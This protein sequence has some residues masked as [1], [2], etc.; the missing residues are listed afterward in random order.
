MKTLVSFQARFALLLAAS[1]FVITTATADPMAEIASFSSLKIDAQKIAS[2][3]ILSARSPGT[4]FPRGLVIESAFIVNAPFS[5]SV[6][7][8]KEWNGRE[9][10]ELKIFLHGDL[11]A[12]PSPADFQK[13]ASAPNNASVRALVTAS[14]R[15]A[16]SPDELQISQAEAADAPK[17]RGSTVSA[18]TPFWSKVLAKRCLA[19]VSG[20]ASNQPPYD[21]SNG[22]VKPAE[23][24][25]LLLK[26]QP[27]MRAQFRSILDGS[28]ITSQPA[29]A[30]SL[31]WELV[32]ADG[33][34]TLNLGASFLSHSEKTAQA[35]DVQY[36]ATS[37]YFAYLTLYQLWPLE[38]DGKPATVVW[39]AD[40]ISA[41]S[42]ATLHGI[43][44]NA[45]GAAMM[46]ELQKLIAFFQKD[47]GGR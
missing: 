34:A 27:K 16:A 33:Q 5:K 42:L 21:L 15:L 23:E 41:S 12:S 29:L 3:N 35:V 44:R 38:S 28:G 46:K 32:D 20:G 14:Q 19:F 6:E 43:E 26:S 47:N 9:H 31:Y 10:P 36:Y 7:A 37:S 2:G 11:P 13:L 4:N 25:T 39:R 30:P 8:V 22:K 18:L 45:A 40:L 24:F 1:C 17:D